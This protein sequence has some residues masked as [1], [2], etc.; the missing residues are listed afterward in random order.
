MLFYTSCHFNHH[1]C[2]AL[3]EY[4][5]FTFLCTFKTY[6]DMIDTVDS[7][8]CY[9]AQTLAAARP[10]AGHVPRV[11]GIPGRVPPVQAPRLVV[12]HGHALAARVPALAHGAARAGAVLGAGAGERGAV[13]GPAVHLAVLDR[14]RVFSVQGVYNHTNI[15]T[16]LS[17]RSN[18]THAHITRCWCTLLQ[19]YIAQVSSV[20]YW[21]LDPS[22]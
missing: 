3:F 15:Y 7:R 21:T 12:A 5:V 16:Q 11:P 18:R 9:L 22:I 6:G 1:H 10:H 20:Y 14:Y 8:Y 19:H 2:I 4:A 17:L 13:L